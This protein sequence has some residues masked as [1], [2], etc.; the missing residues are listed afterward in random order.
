MITLKNWHERMAD[1]MRLRDYS[2]KT[3]EAYT[4]E[5]RQFMKHVGKEPRELVEEDLRAYFIYLKEERELA[6]SSRNVAMHGLRFF[7][8]HT[9]QQE[10]PIFDLVR[11]KN[12]QKL[13]TVLSEAETWQVLNAVRQPV[14]RMALVTIYGLGLRLGEALRLEAEHID[15]TRL[16]VWVR[17]GKGR[18][19]RTV[20]L[21]RPLLKRLRQYWKNEREAADGRL[22]F[23]RRGGATAVH[24]TTL[25]KT[26]T[27]AL[28]EQR[29]EKPASIHTLRHS[30]ATHLLEAGI[31]LKTIQ[32]L[33]GHKSLKTTSVY[34]HVT[35]ASG[36]RLQETLDRLLSKA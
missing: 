7:F 17:D 32:Q 22:L 1:D 3:Q 25:Q 18:K 11:V 10:W 2:R 20:P 34:L 24:E 16:M 28:R 35:Q 5:A 14:R 4:R 33:L 27:A 29:L 15:S 8:Q 19:D 6:P 23:V 12:P 26:F 31:T 30:Y 36:E 9:L 13:P 21:P